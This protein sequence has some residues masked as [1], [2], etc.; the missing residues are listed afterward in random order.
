MVL[1]ELDDESLVRIV[2]EGGKDAASAFEQ[3]YLRCTPELIR[4]LASKGLASCEIDDVLANTWERVFRRIQQFEYQGVRFYAWLRAFAMNVKREHDRRLV[5][6]PLTEEVTDRITA[7]EDADAFKFE[8]RLDLI[9]K[10]LESAPE[11]FRLRI[12]AELDGFTPAEVGALYGWSRA[13]TDKVK[14]RAI[15]WIRNKIKEGSRDV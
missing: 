4:A 11:D 15:P 14:S 12:E 7:E 1:T 6:M 13:K 10:A 8:R 9:R 3:L 5:D 2:Q